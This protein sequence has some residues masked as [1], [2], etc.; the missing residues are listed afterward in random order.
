[1]TAHKTLPKFRK[2][3]RHTVFWGP[4]SPILATSKVKSR[5]LAW[6]S[7]LS[8]RQ[9]SPLAMQFSY[10]CGAKNPKLDLWVNTVTEFA[11]WTVLS[12]KKLKPGFCC[13]LRPPAWKWGRLYS[14]SRGD[15]T[16][17][18]D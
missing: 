15:Q 14:Y 6:R 10:P 2:N 1:M 8:P 3:F 9:I 13:R 7:R 4:Y 12:V 5:N 18:C 17:R 16:E 11:P